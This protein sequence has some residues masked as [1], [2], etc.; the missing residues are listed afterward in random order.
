MPKAEISWNADCSPLLQIPMIGLLEWAAEQAPE[1]LF[2]KQPAYGNTPELAWTYAEF[3]ADVRRLAAYLGQYFSH[4]DNVAIWAPNSAHWF[5]YQFAASHLGL[6]LVTV[7]PAMRQQEIEYML[8]KSEAKG[9]IMDR[10]FRG[11]D[12]VAMLNV[13][14]PALPLLETTLYLDEWRRHIADAPGAPPPCRT[15]PEDPALIVFTSGTTGKPKGAILGQ[16]ACVNAGKASAERGG[17]PEGS[18]WLAT[19]PVFHCG[20]PVTLCLGAVS[21]LNTMV[22]MP[23]FEPGMAL[24]LIEQEKIT[25]APLVP[26]MLIP[27]IE[28]EKF[29]ST[30]ISSLQALLFGGTTLTPS[31]LHL[32]Q[33]KTGAEVQTVFG[34][35]EGSGSILMTA[36]GDPI[37]V[38]AETVGTPLP[39]VNTRIVNP[40][41]GA[42]AEI[43]EIG[44]IRYRSPYMTL[45]YFGDEAA[46]AALF[47]DEGYLRSGDLGII[48]GNGRIHITGRLK[49]LIIR[50]GMNIYPREIEDALATHPSVAEAA[51]IGLPHDKYGEEVAVAV[52]GVAGAT[53]D[54]TALREY[55]IDRVARYK[56]PK[57]WRQ[58]DDFPRSGVGK[59]QKF[60]MKALFLTEEVAG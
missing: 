5:L 17:L 33:E 8:A 19:L 43:G 12:L 54:L 13:A 23:P 51:V 44:E 58:V 34:M 21:K 29:A 16:A 57:H 47:D 42:I 11:T 52:R 56:V 28:H 53:L 10:E 50:S 41:T 22:I 4:G 9:V 40:A 30:D 32:A 36:R 27:M 48:D 39:H 6:L 26:A 2:I 25:W 46:T 31:F 14:R 15:R 1:R 7:N 24:D 59:I 45:G 55:L 37:E 35:T 49:E 3:L 60:E 18:V 38:V 20:G